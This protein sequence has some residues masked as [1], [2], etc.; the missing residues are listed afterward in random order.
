MLQGSCY[1][2]LFDEFN[3]SIFT[4][5]TYSIESALHEHLLQSPHRV[6]DPDQ[7]DFFYVPV[8]TSCF[9]HPVMGW[10]D[11]PWW[12]GPEG[13]PCKCQS[14]SDLVLAPCQD[15]RTGCQQLLLQ[16]AADHSVCCACSTA[17]GVAACLM[18]PSRPSS[19]EAH[20][21]GSPWTWKCMSSSTALVPPAT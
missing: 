6:L 8:Y 16:A 9:M 11:Y 12:Y 5:W 10:A 17:S 13:G 2:R 7:A 14:R 18:Q 1:W 4:R 19:V 21:T 20:D 3:A 15:R